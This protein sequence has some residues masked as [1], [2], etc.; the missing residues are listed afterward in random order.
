MVLR[1]SFSGLGRGALCRNGLEKQLFGARE[2]RCVPQWG[3]ENMHE[4]IH[5]AMDIVRAR[6][7]W[8][9]ARPQLRIKQGVAGVLSPN[10]TRGF[11]SGRLYSFCALF[12]LSMVPGILVFKDFGKLWIFMIFVLVKH[13]SE[14]LRCLRND[15][16]PSQ[17][18]QLG[19]GTLV[20]GFRAEI[21]ICL[22]KN[23][24]DFHVYLNI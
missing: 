20:T 13:K 21:Q 8:D 16:R 11:R 1:N 17:K 2:G 10:C 19:F 15:P 5:G 7:A 22:K 4:S 24:M 3:L 6:F 12:H 9:P 14:F 18:M 23:N